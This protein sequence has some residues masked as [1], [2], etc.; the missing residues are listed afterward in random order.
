MHTPYKVVI[1][2]QECIGKT[3]LVNEL[4]NKKSNGKYNPTLSVEM[5]ICKLLNNITLNLWDTAGNDTFKGDDKYYYYSDLG[6]I[7]INKKTELS[8][9]DHYIYK[10][11]NIVFNIPIIIYC[12][13]INWDI[14]DYLTI[15]N[16]IHLV[17][18]NINHENLKRKILNILN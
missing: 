5:Q 18:I 15:D 17:N 13:D 4:A 2:G 3:K 6:I 9:I 14:S 10:L 8:L 11:R 1:I 7:V 12:N 16:N